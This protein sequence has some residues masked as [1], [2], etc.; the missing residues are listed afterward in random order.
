VSWGQGLGFLLTWPLGILASIFFVALVPTKS[1]ALQCA[2]A[3]VLGAIVAYFSVFHTPEDGAYN[4]VPSGLG[5]YND[6]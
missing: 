5:I 3:I 4:C 2:A 1:F 6:C